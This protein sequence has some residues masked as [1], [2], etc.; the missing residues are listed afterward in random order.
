M[1]VPLEAPETTWLFVT[2][3]PAASITTP[4]PWPSPLAVVT[5]I[6]TTA[7]EAAAATVAQSGLVGSPCTTVV[8]TPSWPEVVEAVAPD[9]DPDGWPLSWAAAKPA[10][11][12]TPAARSAT[13]RTPATWER[14]FA[15]VVFGATV[16]VGCAACGVPKA[17]V[18][19]E[20]QVVNGPG[21]PCCVGRSWGVA[22][23]WGPAGCCRPGCGW[24]AADGA[25]DMV[26][27]A[28]APAWFSAPW[29]CACCGALWR[30]S[31]PSRLHGCGYC[32]FISGLLV[33]LLR[34]EHPPNL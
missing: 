10:P 22:V 3:W 30:G 12:P 17:V 11:P 34:P 26:V 1:T 16:V 18:G 4:E 27:W 24:V 13:A 15:L 23:G 21:W 9:A 2:M 20:F 8:C 32:S 25:P 5:S 14:P 19:P 31:V 6:A 29:G 28:G 33:F 7:R